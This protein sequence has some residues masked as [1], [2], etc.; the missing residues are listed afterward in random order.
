MT[1]KQLTELLK[2]KIE[3]TNNKEIDKIVETLETAIRKEI[4][5][6][7]ECKLLNLG[8]F[9]VKER[10]ERKGRNPKTGEELTIPASKTVSFKPSASF[11]SQVNE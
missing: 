4:I 1:K 6:T 11:K 10:A 9:K 8:I 5:E 3:T 7:G 2:S